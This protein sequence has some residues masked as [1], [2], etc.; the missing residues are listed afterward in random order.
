MILAEAV[1]LFLASLQSEELD[2]NTSEDCAL[3]TGEALIPFCK[4]LHR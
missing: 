3:K 2:S 4:L 1:Q